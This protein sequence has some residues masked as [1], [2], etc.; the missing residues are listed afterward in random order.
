MRASLI[1]QEPHV[2]AYGDGLIGVTTD[3]VLG[4]ESE[5]QYGLDGIGEPLASVIASVKP[6]VALCAEPGMGKSH[7][8]EKLARVARGQKKDVLS[9]SVDADRTEGRIQRFVRVC[10]DTAKKLPTCHEPL[11]IVDDICPLDE[12]EVQSA[13]RALTKLS[14]RGCR[15]VICLR[16]EAEQLVE[17]LP[18]CRILRCEE[19]LFR[20]ADHDC[21]GWKMTGGIPSL[22]DGYRA[23]MLA[24]RAVSVGTK[25]GSA[26]EELVDKTLRREL[27]LEEQRVRLAMLL[28]GRGTLEDVHFVSG[29]CD[30]E[31]FAWLRKD[32][33]LLGV[34]RQGDSFVCHGMAQDEVLLSCLHVLQVHAADEQQIVVRACG[35]LASRGEARRSAAICA[36]LSSERS[37]VGVCMTWGATYVASG[38]VKLVQDALRTARSMGCHPD[39]RGVLSEAA[40]TML[41][42]QSADVVRMR[43]HVEGLE[44]STMSEQALYRQVMLLSACREIWRNPRLAMPGVGTPNDDVVGTAAIMHVQAARLLCAGHFDEAYA[45]L[46]N[47]AVVH[48]VH[49]IPTALLCDDAHIALL[50]SGGVPDR[51]ERRL[52]EEACKFFSRPKMGHLQ[53][54]H[55]AFECVPAVLMGWSHETTALEDATNAAERV[56]DRYAH[57]L[58]LGVMAVRDVRSGALS[59]A[60]VRAEKAGSLA[61]SIGEEYL[62]SAAELV[63]AL[64]L[65][66]LGETGVL[67]SWCK[68]EERPT[69]L[70]LLGKLCAYV[71]GELPHD[72]SEVLVPVTLPFPRDAL[73][74]FR[75]VAHD[76]RNIS[77]GIQLVA[78]QVWKELLGAVLLRQEPLLSEADEA[79]PI[80]EAREEGR[81]RQQGHAL[82][83]GEQGRLLTLAMQRERVRISVMGS[84]GVEVDGTAITEKIL[85]RR[86]A[87]DLVMLLAVVPSHRL[88]RYQIA[89]ILWPDSDYV[90]APRKLYE[91]TGEARKQL[92]ALLD[93]QNPLVADRSQ[94]S[95]GYDLALVGCDVDDFEREARLVVS[96]DDNDLS[97]LDHARRME[98][99]YAKGPDAHLSSLGDRVAERLSELQTMFVD[100]SVAAGEAAL[101]L[102]RTKIAVHF[103]FEAHR[104]GDLREDAMILLVNALRAAGRGYE[105]AGYYRAFSRHLIEAEGV[106]PSLALRRAAA[107]AADNGVDALSA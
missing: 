76:C 4:E 79:N 62:A 81:S 23:D 107:L 46:S 87:R 53:V 66:L 104:N 73:W 44:L 14:S 49:C 15:M 83:E 2:N 24:G 78:P 90:R 31:Q 101:R 55:A 63:D 10:R 75:L 11:V 28:L 12:W 16:P 38:E 84:F 5:G 34:G 86:R 51:H 3:R 58:F 33:P 18:A 30:A 98:R 32:V 61:S 56:G 7:V 68:R 69:D 54:Y 27:P 94:G 26:I 80:G 103:A 37:Y 91:A 70:A 22:V 8:A 97:V 21:D 50:L 77:E 57:A 72:E 20:Y 17:A 40:V 60:H 41:V 96:E 47:G 59:R 95:I 43:E 71:V 105:V 36:L 19:L 85:D 42:G 25:Y 67:G 35:L 92:G 99:L 65:S 9:I 102:G 82:R 6:L 106:P 1:E 64:A 93:G 13:A 48:E 74:L 100:A 45:R 52:R 88:R 39:T 29:R 89:E